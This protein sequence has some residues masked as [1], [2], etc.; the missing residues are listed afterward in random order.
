MVAAVAVQVAVQ[1][2]VPAV[3]EAVLA[4]AT[5][6]APLTMTADLGYVTQPTASV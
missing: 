5:G 3:Q 4:V 6:P 1:E 2:D